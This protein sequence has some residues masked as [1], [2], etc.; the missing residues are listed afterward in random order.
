[1]QRTT[2]MH[3]IITKLDRS[4]QIWGDRYRT[5]Q[6]LTNLLSNAIKYSPQAKKI[7]VSSKI[8]GNK[9][10]ICVE[11][12]GIG[13]KKDHLDKVFDRFFRVSESTLNTFPGL[14]LGLH[15]SEEI[16]RKQGGTIEVRSTEGKGSTFCFS[17]PLKY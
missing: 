2:S 8:A 16:V 17:L 14:G 10:S 5:G 4:V 11:D 13:I 1:M 15:I 7:I 12:F 6:V 3:K 9:I